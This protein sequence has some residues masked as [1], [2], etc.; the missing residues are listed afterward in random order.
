MEIYISIDGVLRNLI[1]KFEF[2]YED[3]YLNSEIIDANQAD[4]DET[5]EVVK[6]ITPQ[7]EYGINRPIG[8]D[9]LM[10]YF[11]FQT[12]EEFET[13]LYFDYAL[14]IFGNSSLNTSM[15]NINRIIFLNNTINFTFIGIN[16]FGKAS[17]ATLFFLAKNGFLGKNIK[18]ITSNDIDKEWK[19]CDVWITDNME[20]LNKK[21]KT[22]K[23][24][25]F[26]TE[27]NRNIPY[28]HSINNLTDIKLKCL[29][30]SEKTTI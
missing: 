24:F 27:H 12:K 1:Q 17:S 14:E 22:K 25:K 23:G 29:Q 5:E 20:I 13:F 2:H 4:I 19:K 18:F 15:T 10:K 8:N 7:F 26:N 28:K 21:P 6:E 3:Y 16:E 11:K 9:D 30:F